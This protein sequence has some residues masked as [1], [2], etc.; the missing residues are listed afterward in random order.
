MNGLWLKSCEDLFHLYSL[1]AVHSY[2]L[3]HIHMMSFSSI[4][5]TLGLLPVRFYSSTEH[6]TGTVDVM[7]S[8][9]IEVSEFFPGFICNCL[10]YYITARITFACKCNYV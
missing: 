6:C 4:E 9:S 2:D 1:S 10:S 3:D 8:N 7:G 5:L